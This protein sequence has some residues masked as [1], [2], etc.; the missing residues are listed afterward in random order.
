M[1]LWLQPRTCDIMG[2][3]CTLTFFT[4]W[5]LFVNPVGKENTEKPCKHSG[6]W[7]TGGGTGEAGGTWA[8]ESS[9]RRGPDVGAAGPGPGG[10]VWTV[11]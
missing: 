8:S 3:V 6:T 11:E 9:A 2:A 7:A 10:G 4:S 1:R 5:S